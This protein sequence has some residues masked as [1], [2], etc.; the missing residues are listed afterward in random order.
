MYFKDLK[1]GKLYQITP[2]FFEAFEDAFST[3]EIYHSIIFYKDSLY[4]FESYD[5]EYYGQKL[6]FLNQK[7]NFSHF[8]GIGDFKYQLN[9]L[10]QQGIVNVLLRV[11]EYKWYNFNI[12]EV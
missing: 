8:M 6:I 10:S 3:N 2:A 11:E 12:E 7:F 1:P 4:A 9:F 5:K